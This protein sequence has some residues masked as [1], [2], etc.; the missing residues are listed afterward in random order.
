MEEKKSVSEK[1]EKSK[2]MKEVSKTAK[3]NSPA[4]I[5]ELKK[6]KK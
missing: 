6:R 4:D 3:E 5:F 2:S 1:K